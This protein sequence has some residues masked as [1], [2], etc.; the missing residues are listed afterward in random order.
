MSCPFATLRR[1]FR[2]VLA[3]A[4]LTGLLAVWLTGGGQSAHVCGAEDAPASA[5]TREAPPADVTEIDGAGSATKATA[6]EFAPQ[7]IMRHVDYLCRPELEGRLTGTRGEQLATAYVAAYMDNLGLQPGGDGGTFFQRF[8]FTAGVAL[9]KDNSLTWGDRQYQVDQDYV[10]V[11]FSQTGR[12]EAAP[13]VFAGYGIAAPG[14]DQHD[15]YDSFVHLDVTGKWVLVFRYLPELV[16][17]ERRQ[18]L[19][20]HAS[21]RYKA[22]LARDKGACGLILVSGPNSQVKQPLVRLQFDGTLAGASVPVISVTDSVAQQWLAENGKNLKELQDKLDS[23]QP[24]MGFELKAARLSAS[25]DI[26]QVKRTGRNVL[27]YLRAGQQPAPQMLVVGAHVD[28][29]GKGPSSSSLAR[30][31]E[32]E[33]IHFGADDNASGVAGILGIAKYLAD[34]QATGRWRPERDILFAA[35]SGEELGLIGS[36][37]F[38]KT[39]PVPAGGAPAGPAAE[40]AKPAD[41]HKSPPA[42]SHGSAPLSP[43]PAIAAC[44]NLD[45]IGRLDKK[46][47]L[48]GVGSS[49]IWRGEIERHNDPVGLPISLQEDSYL[50]T[51]ANVFYLRGVPI[52]AA[53]TGSHPEYHTPRD[54]PDKLNY[55]GAARISRLMALIARSLATRDS[56]PDYVAQTPPKS[57]TVRA[58]MRAYLGTIPDYAEGDVQGVQLS[59]VAATGPAGKAGAKGGDVIVELAGKKIDN[60]YDYTYAIEALKIGQPV[61]LVVQ[62]DA[63]RIEMTVIPTSRE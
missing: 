42:A 43:Y 14:D 58:G 4:A 23:G 53:F 12:V 2:S 41:P 8:E 50:P 25:I 17:A 13:V 44:L 37:H 60:I 6:A 32:R 34:Q 28:H 51:D 45:M 15:E 31:D 11:S 24:V 33:E 59:G 49:S 18:H 36:S 35:W 19:A 52:L 40:P 63:E 54:T 21:L 62:R 61:K 9:G 1:C 56:P 48:Q 38:I 55:D 10:P 26:Q 46:L 57:G 16:S 47:T 5:T 20:R 39:F 29:L 30:D 7:D 27:G 3:A 22:M